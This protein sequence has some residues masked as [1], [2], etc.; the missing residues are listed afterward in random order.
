MDGSRSEQESAVAPAAGAVSGA[1]SGAGSASGPATRRRRERSPLLPA[2]PM[3]SA[4][5]VV[6]LAGIALAAPVAWQVQQG[7]N[8]GQHQRLMLALA[9]G[10]AAAAATA[11]GSLPALF[12][13]SYSQRGFDCFL[14]FGAGVM[15]A[16]TAFSLLVPALASAGTLIAGRTGAS[17]LV[18]LG[19]LTGVAAI[20]GLDRIAGA[21][22]AASGDGGKAAPA[23]AGA[24]APTIA[25]ASAP[26]AS[27]RRVWLF[28]AAVTLHNVPEGLAIGVAYAGIDLDKAATLAT[29][30][31]VQDLPEGL[32]IALAFRSVGYGRLRATALGMASGLVEP[33]ASLGGVLLVGMSVTLLPLGLAAAAGAM[34]FVIVNEVVPETHL[35]GNG[36]LASCALAAGFAAMLVLDTALG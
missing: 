17:L 10:G 18:A 11:L 16:A 20:T 12:S 3:R 31:A 13:R 34:L 24:N 19:L 21:L 27:L 26:A 8:A 2:L 25:E 7:W 6:A 29:G 32:V 5:I 33:V 35:H 28:M 4:L 23:S 15:L 30:I 36:T 1:V 9:A 14:G 22:T